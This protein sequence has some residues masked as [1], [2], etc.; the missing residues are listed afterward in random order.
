[1]LDPAIDSNAISEP[2]FPLI[3]VG[4]DE[5][6]ITTFFWPCKVMVFPETD[7]VDKPL[8]GSEMLSLA[9]PRAEGH[10]TAG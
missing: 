8:L 7:P 1:M 3:K 2:G 6:R 10:T 4:I 9:P 5:P